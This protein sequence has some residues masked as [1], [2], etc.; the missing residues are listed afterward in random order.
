MTETDNAVVPQSQPAPMTAAEADWILRQQINQA[1]ASGVQNWFQLGADLAVACFRAKRGGPEIVDACFRQYN[2][3]LKSRLILRYSDPQRDA[4]G[5]ISRVTKW[6][7]EFNS[8]NAIEIA[9]GFAKA[10]W[11]LGLRARID[12]DVS[13]TEAD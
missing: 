1:A 4:T 8:A 6:E 5:F 12:G 7:A 10:L 2:A 3:L 13:G 9:G 11:E